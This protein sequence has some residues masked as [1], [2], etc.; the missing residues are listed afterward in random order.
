MLWKHILRYALHAALVFWSRLD[1]VAGFSW[2][3]S[4]EYAVPMT[5]LFNRV[6]NSSR[7]GRGIIRVKQSHLAIHH[8][9]PDFLID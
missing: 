2:D 1:G 6:E 8:C 9:R 7:L 3:L 4:P 5:A